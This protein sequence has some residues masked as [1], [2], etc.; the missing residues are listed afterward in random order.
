VLLFTDGLSTLS[1]DVPA[2][3]PPAPV[4]I[5]ANAPQANGKTLSFIGR[6]FRRESSM[7]GCHAEAMGWGLVSSEQDRWTVL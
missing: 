5:F 1:G 7:G 3:L 2:T 6:S 4:Y